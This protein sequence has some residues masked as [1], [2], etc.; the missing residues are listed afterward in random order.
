MIID[1]RSDTVTQPT[2]AMWDAMRSAP[3]GDDVLGDEPTVTQLE[4][5]C[6]MLLGKEAALF[7]Q[8]WA[9]VAKESERERD[10]E[11]SP[12]TG[13]SFPAQKGKG[14]N[15]LLKGQ[16]RGHGKNKRRPRGGGRG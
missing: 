8:E 14:L 16:E 4:D 11:D 2:D 10:E 9:A 5:R 13:E 12:M 7:V 15:T 1:L 3:L 6:S